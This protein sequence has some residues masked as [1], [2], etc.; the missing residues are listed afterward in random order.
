MSSRAAAL[1][2][3]AF[4]AAAAA[5]LIAAAPVQI[6]TTVVVP[7]NVTNT[8]SSSSSDHSLSYNLLTKKNLSEFYDLYV[9]YRVA[10]KEGKSETK[11]YAVPVLI[12]NMPNNKARDDSKWTFTSRIFLVW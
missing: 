2:A 3:A 1:A 10:G 8:T 11:L 6:A 12:E 4:I 7:T 9:P 5:A